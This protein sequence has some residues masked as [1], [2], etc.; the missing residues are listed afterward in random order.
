VLSQ[1]RKAAI[2][3]NRLHRA[4]AACQ[5]HWQEKHAAQ[6]I[7]RP[8]WLGKLPVWLAAPRTG[9]LQPALAG[10]TRCTGCL[11]GCASRLPPAQVTGTTE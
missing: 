2:R 8:H 10:Q 1:A 3:T 7:C 9:Q 11:T 6:I 4:L 5:P